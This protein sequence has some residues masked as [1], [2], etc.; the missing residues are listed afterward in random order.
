MSGKYRVEPRALGFGV[1]D[2]HE[3]LRVPRAELISVLAAESFLGRGALGGRGRTWGRVHGL[4][5]LKR[6]R[7]DV[8][9]GYD[10]F[11]VTVS[12]RKKPGFRGKQESKEM[13]TGIIPI[14]TRLHKRL[15][16]LPYNALLLRAKEMRALGI[17]HEFKAILPR[18]DLLVRDD[19][20]ARRVHVAF[21]AH[22]LH[23]TLQSQRL[24]Q[25]RVSEDEGKGGW[26]T[27]GL[28]LLNQYKCGPLRTKYRFFHTLYLSPFF[29]IHPL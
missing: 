1:P 14:N 12:T 23:Q 5:D 8:D 7:G 17:M 10:G 11:C 2:A 26:R 4:R 21:D 6:N 29:L 19:P 15:H 27:E 25:H 28:L 13:R 16:P 3:D 20:V 18:I 9:R 22:L 24:P